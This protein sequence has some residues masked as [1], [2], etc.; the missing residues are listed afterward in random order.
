MTTWAYDIETANWTDL[1]VACA[2]SSDGRKLVMRSNEETARWYQSLPTSDEVIAHNGGSF[3]FLQLIES[4][5]EL[6]WHAN[7]AG[8]TIVSCRAKGHALCRDSYRLFPLSLAKWTRRKSETGLVCVCG[9]NCGGYCAI[10]RSMSAAALARLTAY[11]MNDCEVLLATWLQDI[12]RLEAD[13]LIVRT[14]Q[15]IRGTIGGVAWFTGATMA[16]LDPDERPSWE[17]YMAGRAGYYGGRTEV[18]Q[19]IADEVFQYDANAVYPWALTLDVPIGDRISFTGAA[20][21]KAYE[22]DELGI[23]RAS[24]LL[25]DNSLPALPHRL[26]GKIAGRGHRHAGD[27]IW[28]TGFVNGSWSGIELRSAERHGAKVLKIDRADTWTGRAPIFRAYVEMVYAARRRAIDAGDDRWGAVLK[29]FAN[30]LS[31]KLAQRPVT[32]SIMVIGKHEVPDLQ[33]EQIGGLRSRV[34]ATQGKRETPKSGLTWVA[35]TLTAR[36]RVKLLDRLMRHEATWLYCDTDS[37]Y[38][39]VQDD[40]DVHQSRLGW[41]KYEGRGVSGVDPDTGE[42]RRA[43]EARAPKF[44]RVRH[45]DG[46]THVRIRGV[47]RAT[48]DTFDALAGGRAVSIESVA[49]LRSGGGSFKRRDLTRSHHDAGSRWVG[50]RRVATWVGGRTRPL[51]RLPDGTYA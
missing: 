15:G 9:R 21:G 24:L 6:T 11:C 36:A 26:V 12:A 27:M 33:W 28:A 30:S 19:T 40:L 18:G 31:G 3:D 1:V 34:F 42:T 50:T 16:G 39:A 46:H 49:R 13:G 7:M 41:F 10:S 43:W 17:D 14:K 4:C 20:A 22:R 25:P 29:W 51:R 37:T 35:A 8:G 23:Y 38:L 44:Y 32:Q 48:W 2:V 45:E 5:P 47:P